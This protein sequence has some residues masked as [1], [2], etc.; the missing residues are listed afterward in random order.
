MHKKQKKK[1]YK[2]TELIFESNFLSKTVDKY[3]CSPY[4]KNTIWNGFHTKDQRKMK[5]KQS[6][7]F[8][9]TSM[10]RIPQYFL[11]RGGNRA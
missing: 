11:S 2:Y 10:E 5:N 7:I 6:E 1:L 4:D 9:L 8:F 3:A